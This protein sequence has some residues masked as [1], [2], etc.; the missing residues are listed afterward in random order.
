MTVFASA[1]LIHR[2]PQGSAVLFLLN[3]ARRPVD[4]PPTLGE[5][6]RFP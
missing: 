1:A 2:K 5:R 6:P 4:R 3:A